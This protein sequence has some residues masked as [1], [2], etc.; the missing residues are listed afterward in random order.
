MIHNFPELVIIL[1]M[2]HRKIPA[3]K[4]AITYAEWHSDFKKISELKIKEQWIRKKIC[5]YI[6]FYKKQ[7]ANN[8]IENRIYGHQFTKLEKYFEKEFDDNNCDWVHIIN[9][10]S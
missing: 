2:Y 3:I 7:M 4:T 6:T 5:S 9:Q 8:Y 10:E 1:D